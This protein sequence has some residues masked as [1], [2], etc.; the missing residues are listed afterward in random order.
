MAASPAPGGDGSRL[1]GVIVLLLFGVVI[2]SMSAV[3]ESMISIEVAFREV[4]SISNGFEP[5]VAIDEPS[6]LES[7][8]PLLPPSLIV[9]S[10]NR[11]LQDSYA[12][13]RAK[14]GYHSLAVAVNFLYA[15]RWNYDFRFY[16]IALNETAAAAQGAN[17]GALPRNHDH[18]HSGACY[19]VGRRELR[20]APWCKILPSWLATREPRAGWA[21]YLDSD[22]IFLDD[23]RSLEYV[24]DDPAHHRLTWGAPLSNTTVGFIANLPWMLLYPV[25]CMYWFRPGERARRFMQFWWD[26][27]VIGG[28]GRALFCI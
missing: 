25:S 18:K 26:V 9:M 6:V 24:L 27:E 14:N 16:Q 11:P 15:R 10:D 12:D 4:T 5:R 28:A 19:H 7:A 3:R 17:V 21:V 23:N 13:I 2:V 22:I 1:V 8:T 20:S